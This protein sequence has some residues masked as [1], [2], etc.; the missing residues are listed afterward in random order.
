MNRLHVLLSARSFRGRGKPHA[1]RVRSRFSSRI[2]R[3]AAPLLAALAAVLC[4][5]ATGGDDAALARRQATL[6]ELRRMLPPS[7]AW[8]A[9][10]AR[11]GELP[12]DFDALPGVAEL[13]DPLRFQDGRP[14]RT[15][16]QWAARRAE[17]LGLFQRYV[18]GT[19]PPPPGNVRAVESRERVEGGV[20]VREVVLAFGPGERAR[21]HLEVLLPPGRGPFPVFLTQDNHRRWALVAVSRGYVG[22]VYAGADSRDDTG[23][24]V[25]V[26]PEADWSK[27]TRRAWAA[28]RCVDYLLTLPEVDAQRLAL[29]G[30]SRNGKTALIAAALDERIRAVISSSSG[31]GGAC[32]WRLFSEA[33]FGEG[34][35][36]ITRAMPDW[37]HPRLRFFVGRENK[38]PV[39][40]HELI[41][42]IAPR[43]VL[44]STALNDDVESVWAIE[45]TWRAARPV[46]A[47]L[48]AAAHLNLR[49]RPGEHSTLAG[50]IEAYV[51]WLDWK[52]GRARRPVA[53][54]PIY[55]T[56]EDW[57]R[58]S[59]ERVRAR[60]F[61]RRGI[62]NV[63]APAGA[64]PLT[65]AAAW[66]AARAQVRARLEW[67]L[68][69][70]PPV[71]T[72][73]GG[74]YGAE[75]RARA[76]LLQRADPPA[77]VVKESLNFGNYIP[78]DLYY[79]T[80]V[81]STERRLPAFIWL[82]PISV[83][84]GYVAGYFRNEMPHLALTR[85]GYAVFA[86]DQIG[87]GG[88]LEEAR[89]FY[90]RYPRWSLLGKTVADTAAAVE[91]LRRHP[92]V[93]PEQIYLLGYGTGAMAALVAAALD[94]RVAGVLAVNGL[95][96]LR[97]DTAAGGTGGV[98]RWA[99][100]LPLLPR[101]GAFVGEE[102]RIPCDWHEVMALV[103]PRPLLVIT[104]GVDYQSRF[105][106]LRLA[107]DAA[108][109][110]FELLGAPQNLVFQRT[111][112][113]HHFNPELIWCLCGVETIR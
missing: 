4:G 75:S 28:S 86:F 51:D 65:N 70:P 12:P 53:D 101:L 61:P 96:P 94:E 42:C 83:S 38:L 64:A 76:V 37:F 95:T 67:L 6:A 11:S 82:H 109:P 14:V 85:S 56:Y 17:L 36:L 98:A 84:H 40:Q 102:R 57:Q 108:R 99:Q 16:A 106:Y 87:H 19:V 25:E 62:E 32:S 2:H 39:D 69:E 9:W 105:E 47:R 103:A 35:E 43:P 30:H 23:A 59:G 52:F 104:P 49:Y 34:I 27:L 97:L 89:E 58:A 80:N 21:L 93:D 22:A 113:Y 88:R 107:V 1:P 10:L 29:T 79:P 63:L 68:G 44:L 7:A 3:W 50:D 77:R 111:E 24:W 20:R 91:A 74:R 33:Q 5:L 8:E 13:P 71:A 46:F 92:R 66:T 31:A 73:P 18:L 26:W 48:G 55:P 41:A 81:A 112:D 78:G 90:R 45:H 100:W 72:D 15:R 54:A 110:V 60:D